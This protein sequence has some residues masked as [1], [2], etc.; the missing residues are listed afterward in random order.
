MK[1]QFILLTLFTFALNAENIVLTPEQEANWQIKVEAPQN[2]QRLPLG[3][4]I[5]EVVTPPTLLHT[6]SLPFE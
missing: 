2:S 1:K 3:E 5:S 4:F 6:I